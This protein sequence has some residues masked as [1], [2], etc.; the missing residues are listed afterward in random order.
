MWLDNMAYSETYLCGFAHDIANMNIYYEIPLTTTDNL[1]EM[2]WNCKVH[3]IQ[4]TLYISNIGLKKICML[5]FHNSWVKSIG[6]RTAW[7][8]LGTSRVFIWSLLFSY[9]YD[10]QN[11]IIKGKCFADTQTDF[12][13]TVTA[14]YQQDENDLPCFSLPEIHERKSHQGKY[15]CKKSRS[16]V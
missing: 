15:Y 14:C 11:N 3:E 10:E 5:T 7:Y 2:L 4:I 13:P 6:K 16:R 1:F 12:V 9:N 8:S